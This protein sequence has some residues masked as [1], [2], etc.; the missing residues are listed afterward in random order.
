MDKVHGLRLL[1]KYKMFMDIKC[2]V[3]NNFTIVEDFKTSFKGL[4][5]TFKIIDN[6]I[7]RFEYR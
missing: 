6:E 1:K 3:R 5:R 2:V 4:L 7:E